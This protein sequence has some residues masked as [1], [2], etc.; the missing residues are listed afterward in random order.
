VK[1]RSSVGFAITVLLIA[2]LA[3]PAA[4]AQGTEGLP[5][6]LWD[7]APAE[8]AGRDGSSGNVGL[9]AAVALLAAASVAGFVF[10]KRLPVQVGPRA[11]RFGV[12]GRRPDAC[13][14]VLARSGTR[15]EFQVVTGRGAR[16]AVIGRSPP[17]DVPSSGPVADAG[18]ARAAH[19]V[20]MA[21]LQANGWQVSGPQPA[22]WYR[23]QLAREQA[24]AKHELLST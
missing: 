2:A 11:G 12:A 6:E 3:A 16:R 4:A 15:A 23:A 14:I 13:A 18:L 7:S 17:F 22:P 24:A 9:V 20:L 5:S 19:D 10:G 1:H 21:Q 8:A